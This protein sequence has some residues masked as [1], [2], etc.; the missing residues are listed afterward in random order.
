M[1]SQSMLP[2]S[3]RAPTTLGEE[4]GKEDASLAQLAAENV[5]LQRAQGMVE[6][7][8]ISLVFADRELVIRYAN[9]SALGTL[10]ALQAHLPISV[11]QVIGKPIDLFHRDPQKQRGMLADLRHLPFTKVIDVGPEKVELQIS[12]VYAQDGSVLGYMSAWNIVTRKLA[13]EEEL[14]A[15]TGT[16]ARAT[17]ELSAIAHEIA[18]NSSESSRQ[19]QSSAAAASQVSHNSQSVATA[20]EELTASIRDI[21]RNT[22][23]VASVARD[24]VGISER[25]ADSMKK[26]SASS[27][28]I[29]Q[30]VKSITAIASQTNLLALNATIEAAR[31]GEYGRGFSVVANE[32]KE[33]AKASAAASEDIARRI[34]AIR[35]DTS[36]AVDSIREVGHI[37]EKIHELQGSISSA[38]EEQSAT[39]QEIGRSVAETAQAN[40]EIARSITTVSKVAEGTAAGVGQAERAVAELVQLAVK[41][42]EL[43][44]NA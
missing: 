5:A 42:N 13:L 33:L 30:V 23:E 9:K 38:V 16:L 17:E 44:A 8:P 6:D 21:S 3:L 4:V 24:A 34:Q 26:L 25:T 19:A 2:A 37:I 1:L 36:H 20:I 7:A 39:T 18:S 35:D 12:A 40:G 31:A 15:T 28:Q 11:E 32:V 10:R 27:D 43:V 14:R 22:S 29:G 41:L